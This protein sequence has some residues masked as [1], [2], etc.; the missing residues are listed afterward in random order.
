MGE[1]HNKVLRKTTKMKGI[2]RKGL[3]K[4]ITC[5]FACV[6]CVLYIIPP[7]YAEDETWPFSVTT[8]T[9]S[10]KKFQFTMSAA[11]TFYV[12]CGTDGTLSG[13]G[14]TEN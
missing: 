3:C 8:T 11:G 14:V 6:L 9:L 4:F 13:N 12:D 2:L 10:D 1:K 7:V 5:M